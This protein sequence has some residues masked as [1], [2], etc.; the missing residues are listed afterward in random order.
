MP[1][2]QCGLQYF[3]ANRFVPAPISSRAH[4]TIGY[5]SAEAMK[6]LKQQ[7]L[8]AT[9]KPSNPEYSYYER[10]FKFMQETST[11]LVRA[12]ASLGI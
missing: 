8:P 12:I 11:A 3:K 6:D 4:L 1:A 7:W 2:L 10:R 9:L 5:R